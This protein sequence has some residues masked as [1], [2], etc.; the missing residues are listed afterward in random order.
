M[1][2]FQYNNHVHTTSQTTL[3]LIDT[4]WTLRMGFEAY[5]PSRIEAVNEFVK[6]MKSATEEA[7]STIRKSKDDMAQYY[8]QWQTPAL[9]F[10]PRDKVFLDASNIQTS[11]P[12][13][14]LAQLSGA[15]PCHQ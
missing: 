3:F 4:G 7:C 6:C 12:S 14:K 11:H 1:V 2:E 8:N 9:E 15:F 13:Q 5:T 10:R